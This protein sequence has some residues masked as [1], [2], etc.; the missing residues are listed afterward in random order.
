MKW[1]IS[2]IRG[3]KINKNFVS[4]GEGKW[5]SLKWLN[6]TK[7]IILYNIKSYHR[8]FFSPVLNYIIFIK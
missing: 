4:T 7:K 5:K 8:R 2:V 3:K 6:K 1:N